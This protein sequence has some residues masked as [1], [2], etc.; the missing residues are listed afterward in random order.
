MTR[1]LR[2]LA[3]LVVVG[4]AAPAAAQVQTGSILVK[5]VDDQGA[6]VPGAGVTISSPVL[7]QELVGATDSSGIYRMPGLTAG[8][9]TVTTSLSGFQTVIRQGVIVVQG[10]TVSLEIPM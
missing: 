7:P 4:L 5:A 10:Q 2:F 8:T 9:Y 3:V 1:I 6:V